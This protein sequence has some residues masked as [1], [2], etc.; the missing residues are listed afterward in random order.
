MDL[1]DS[2]SAMR[3]LSAVQKR[4]L[5]SLAVGPVSF[6]PGERLWQAGQPVDKAFILVEGTAAFLPKRR[7]TGPVRYRRT[8][9]M[10]TTVSKFVFVDDFSSTCNISLTFELFVPYCQDAS[11]KEEDNF[12]PESRPSMGEDMEMDAIDVVYQFVSH[13]T[14]NRCLWVGWFV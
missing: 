1:L 13:I 5:E 6:A 11:L 3:K 14:F 7:N 2:N 8:S 12:M 10:S 9:G 4:H